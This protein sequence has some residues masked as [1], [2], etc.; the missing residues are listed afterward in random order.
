VHSFIPALSLSLS[1]LVVIVKWRS[2]FCI[3]I[4]SIQ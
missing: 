4:K 2:L 3:E 1:Y